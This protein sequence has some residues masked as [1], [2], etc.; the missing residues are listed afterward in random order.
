MGWSY[1]TSKR[2][3]PP[4]I[5]YHRGAQWVYT[6]RQ[7]Y[8]ADCG[9]GS[10]D[11]GLLTFQVTPLAPLLTPRDWVGMAQVRST[12][13]AFGGCGG[14]GCGPMR[15]VLARGKSVKSALSHH[16]P[17]SVRVHSL[18]L[19]APPLPCRYFKQQ[20][21]GKL[22]PLPRPSLYCLYCASVTYGGEMNSFY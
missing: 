18:P 15:E 5:L 11:A 4:D 10:N 2:T 14:N 12:V 21:S 13:F 16:H 19:P 17:H 1:T 7:N 6:E 9:D 3:K 20:S 8:C 22:L